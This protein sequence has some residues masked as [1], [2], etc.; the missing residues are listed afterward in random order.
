MPRVTR[1]PQFSFDDSLIRLDKRQ[2]PVTQTKRGNYAW[3]QAQGYLYTFDERAGG[4]VRASVTFGHPQDYL[5]FLMFGADV[6]AVSWFC[7]DAPSNTPFPGGNITPTRCG[8]L[9]RP[10]NLPASWSATDNG[11]GTLVDCATLGATAPRVQGFP[12]VWEDSALFGRPLL[13]ANFLVSCT[14]QSPLNYGLQ[15]SRE[16][17][18]EATGQP[19]YIPI[20]LDRAFYSEAIYQAGNIIT[21]GR[22]V[23]HVIGLW[24]LESFTP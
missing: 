3:T 4:W 24:A 5:F 8:A 15:H 6:P 7:V 19:S 20:V 23:Y 1:P 11:Q 17:G 18:E 2:Q 10:S 21:V 13:A 9:W 14:Y 16:T 22:T 12:L